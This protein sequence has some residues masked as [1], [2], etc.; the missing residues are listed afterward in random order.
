MHNTVSSIHPWTKLWKQCVDKNE[1]TH[2][3]NENVQYRVLRPF[4]FLTAHKRFGMLSYNEAKRDKGILFHASWIFDHKSLSETQIRFLQWSSIHDHKFSMGLRS[5]ELLGQSLKTLIPQLFKNVLVSAEVWHDA[6]SCIS[7]SRLDVALGSCGING[8]RTWSMYWRESSVPWIRTSRNL[9]SRAIAPQT[10]TPPAPYLVC[11]RVHRQSR[12]SPNHQ[13]AIRTSTKSFLIAENDFS[14]ITVLI[15]S[16]PRFSS[17]LLY[18]CQHRC[19][20]CPA[21]VKTFSDNCSADCAT[22]HA[23]GISKS[24]SFQ[25]FTGL[26][27]IFVQISHK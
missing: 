16:G 23:F 15:A 5:G 9:R 27:A 22:G 6:P 20:A 1:E 4:D 18:N 17:E 13:R 2:K 8:R 11:F 21:L 3:T 14:E 25:L 19:C 26:R 10:I 12:L 24:V 7:K